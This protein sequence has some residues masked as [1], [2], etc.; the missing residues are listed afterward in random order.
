M[1]LCR[2][3]VVLPSFFWVLPRENLHSLKISYVG[4]IIFQKVLSR[5]QYF[6][7]PTMNYCRFFIQNY[8]I[9]WGWLFFV[10]KWMKYQYFHFGVFHL[11]MI[12]SPF[13]FFDP[14]NRTNSSTAVVFSGCHTGSAVA[15]ESMESHEFIDGCNIFWLP[16]WVRI[17]VSNPWNR[18]NSSTAVVFSGCQTRSAVACPIHRIARIHRRLQGNNP[19]IQNLITW[20][21]IY[22][23]TKPMKSSELL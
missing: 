4:A 12:C 15:C 5:R 23:R 22:G 2:R 9:S 7:V 10:V 21:A 18:T 16:D 20:A 6:Y 17:S 19:A 1:Y 11:L 13:R 8:E 14:Q 3:A